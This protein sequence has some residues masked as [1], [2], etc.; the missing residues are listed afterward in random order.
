MSEAAVAASDNIVFVGGERE[1]LMTSAHLTWTSWPCPLNKIE[2][3]CVTDYMIVAVGDGQLVA[4][5][6]DHRGK[7][8]QAVELEDEPTALYIHR[9]IAY[10]GTASGRLFEFIITRPRGIREWLGLTMTSPMIKLAREL[11]TTVGKIDNLEDWHD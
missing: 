4:S 3:L 11:S 5:M 6:I 2:A 8:W 7:L 1:V 9:N 10:V